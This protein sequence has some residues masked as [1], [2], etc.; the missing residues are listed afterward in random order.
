[1]R[2]FLRRFLGRRLAIVI[3]WPLLLAAQSGSS[4]VTSEILLRASASWNGTPYVAYPNGRPQLTVVKVSVPAHGQ[5]PWH[6]HPIP[7]AAYVESGD[8]TVEDQH[9]TKR[10]FSQ[11]Q[12]IPETVNILHRGFI[13]DKPAVSSSFTQA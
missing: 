4:N 13:G 11:G 5:L 3:L 12:V 1:V 10:H 2:V 6:M 7:N 8:I 9:G